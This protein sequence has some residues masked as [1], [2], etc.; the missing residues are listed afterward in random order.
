MPE[1]ESAYF[2]N[3]T[4]VFNTLTEFYPKDNVINYGNSYVTAWVSGSTR[5][6]GNIVT[7]NS[8][9]FIRQKYTDN[10]INPEDPSL[11][12]VEIDS[13][14]VVNSRY[15]AIYFKK[16]DPQTFNTGELSSLWECLWVSKIDGNTSMPPKT[17]VSDANWYC[18]FDTSIKDFWSNF[19]ACS[20]FDT[21]HDF[22]VQ[23]GDTHFS[24]GKGSGTASSG[25]A[26][27]Q[28]AEAN[29]SEADGNKQNI[30]RNSV[31]ADPNSSGD[32]DL[33]LY[34]KSTQ[35]FVDVTID[36]NGFLKII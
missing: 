8:K 27:L 28:V 15:E 19:T 34:R 6:I 16:H 9:S 17:R 11:E 29:P 12:Y 1:L 20:E 35:T 31:I 7:Y 23:G 33:V 36:E 22:N 30:M 13:Y 21:R 18:I 2:Q 14:N 4:P 32:T 3:I 25:R 5:K 24:G 10:T 26:I